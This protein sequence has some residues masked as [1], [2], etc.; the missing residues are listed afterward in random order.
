MNF[1]LSED[2]TLFRD[3]IARVVADLFP[4][5]RRQIAVAGE[6]GFRD[7]DWRQLAEL[8]CMAAAFP[9]AYGGFDGGAEELMIIADQFGRGLVSLPY[10]ASV[11]LGGHAVLF[12]GSEAHCAAILPGV[13]EGSTKLAL[14][15]AERDAR[16][17]LAHVAARA[18]ADGDGYVLSGQ[19]DVVLYGQ[20]ADLLIVSARTAGEVIDPS[21]VSLFVIEAGTAGLSHADFATHDGTRACNILLDDVRVGADAL[22]G[23]AGSGVETLERVADHANA[24]LCADATGAM[25]HVYEMTLE[26][27]KTRN[28]FGQTL[29]SF[30]ALQHRMVDVYMECELAQSMVLEATLNLDKDAATRRKAVSAAKVAVGEAARHVC[31][32]GVQLHGGI[33]MTMDFPV[34]HYLKRV[35]AMNAL[36][37]DPRHHTAAYAQSLGNAA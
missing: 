31:E 8:G 30:Q 18:T 24:F 23:T 15:C 1:A 4:F 19:K 29:G 33:G 20:C 14:A 13:G 34:G 12:S 2:Q 16:Y 32:E 22:L 28:Q 3:S 26:Y 37:G 11:I 36:F 27:L 6:R 25:W 5:D 21:G 35:M 7:E 10:F 9:E 17:D